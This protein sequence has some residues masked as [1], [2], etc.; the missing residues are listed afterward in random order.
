MLFW[1]P[2]NPADH[3][4]WASRLKRSLFNL[5]VLWKTSLFVNVMCKSSEKTESVAWPDRTVPLRG[6]VAPFQRVCARRA[7]LAEGLRLNGL[8]PA[9]ARAARRSGVG[10]AAALPRAGVPAGMPAVGLAL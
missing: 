3:L 8:F 2:P 4:C 9:T 5:H 10:Q 6:S 7:G 1:T